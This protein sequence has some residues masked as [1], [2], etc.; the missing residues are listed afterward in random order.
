[1]R[2]LNTITSC[3]CCYLKIFGMLNL[4]G[5]CNKEKAFDWT[6]QLRHIDT[7]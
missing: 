3:V 2:Q 1:M 7:V 5:Y 4:V 6:M